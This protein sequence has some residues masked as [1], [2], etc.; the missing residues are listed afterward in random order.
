M[1]KKLLFAVFV[2]SALLLIGCT[3]AVQ[4]PTQI[5]SFVANSEQSKVEIKQ[6][7]P[8]EEVKEQ[9]QEDVF[10]PKEEV[11][12]THDEFSPMQLTMGKRTLVE[13]I[14]RDIK[15]K[16]TLTSSLFETKELGQFDSFAYTFNNP[17]IYM[18][19]NKV[20]HEMNMTIEVK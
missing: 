10:P 6:I 12:I 18:I 3:K 14:N 20:K 7:Q 17:G 1:L 15:K 4:Q 9:V 13:F 8:V 16:Y 5:E 11:I 19:L 2:I